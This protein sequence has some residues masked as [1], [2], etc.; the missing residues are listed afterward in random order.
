MKE[1]PPDA[2]KKP[3]DAPGCPGEVRL[4]SAGEVAVEHHAIPPAGPPN[5]KI[6]SRRPLPLVPD[7][8]EK[9][10]D[11]TLKKDD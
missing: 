10:D 1:Q 7:A 3:K 8:A 11:T 2:K 9:S 5:L 6:H 4:K